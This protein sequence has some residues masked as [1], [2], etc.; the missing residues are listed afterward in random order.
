MH[1]PFFTLRS[2]SSNLGGQYITDESNFSTTSASKWSNPETEITLFN[3]G[4]SHLKNVRIFF[5]Y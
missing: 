5:R 1:L 2:E 4:V 3:H